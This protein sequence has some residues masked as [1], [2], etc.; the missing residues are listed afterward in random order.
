MNRQRAAPVT[1]TV[2]RGLRPDVT[3]RWA[4]G[5]LDALSGALRGAAAE[6]RRIVPHEARL[7][8][9]RVE[10]V[11]DALGRVGGGE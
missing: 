9:D 8:A 4:L 7:L 11:R 6:R 3:I 2:R 5:A 10:R 1:Y